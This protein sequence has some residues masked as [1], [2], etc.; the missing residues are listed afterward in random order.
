MTHLLIS[1][2]IGGPPDFPRAAA[3]PAP[4][5]DR[6]WGQGPTGALGFSRQADLRVSG[7]VRRNVRL[8]WEK[9][10]TVP[11]SH[12]EKAQ[13]MCIKAVD[14][15]MLQIIQR[16]NGS[17]WVGSCVF[18]QKLTNKSNQASLKPNEISFLKENRLVFSVFYP[19]LERKTYVHGW[20][21]IRRKISWA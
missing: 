11:G 7:A 20:P 10:Y 19:R 1:H 12:F 17:V 6:A 21:P 16:K 15:C 5:Q 9:N 4:L 18:G 2:S 14:K 13:T 3:H 8:F